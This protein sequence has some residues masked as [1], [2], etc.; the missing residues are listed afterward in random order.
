MLETTSKEGIW[1]KNNYGNNEPI[2]FCKFPDPIIGM[3]EC[4]GK[5]FVST[6]KQV[7]LV[8]AEGN[9]TIIQIEG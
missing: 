3:I 8:D 6:E 5:L 9:K 4:N 2:L 1:H 7:Y